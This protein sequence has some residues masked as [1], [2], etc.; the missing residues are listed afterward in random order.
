MKKEVREFFRQHYSRQQ[1]RRPSLM[2]NLATKKL[3]EEDNEML[4]EEF[5]KEEV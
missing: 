1:V 3:S 5:T 2:Q 4:C